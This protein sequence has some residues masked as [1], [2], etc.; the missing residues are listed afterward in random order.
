MLLDS[1]NVAMPVDGTAIAKRPQDGPVDVRRLGLEGD[2]VGSPKHHGGIDQAAYAYGVPDYEWWEAELGRR[3]PPAMFGE[4]LTITELHSGLCSVGDLLRIGTALFQVTSPRIPCETLAR[5]MGD[6][7]FIGRFREARRPGVYLRVLEQG[8]V[9]PG[10]PVTY[11]PAPAGALSILELQ[12]LFYAR[13][14]PV[15]DL[16][17]ALRA[18]IDVRSR[19]QLVRRLLNAEQLGRRSEA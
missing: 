18:P 16:E 14:A 5:R 19:R 6:P 2:G 7:G 15:A 9:T 12:E 17:R 13:E 1:V 10:D 8:V 11:E 4:N 3:L